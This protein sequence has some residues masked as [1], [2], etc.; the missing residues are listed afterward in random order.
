MIANVSPSASNYRRVEAYWNNI[1]LT[2][3]RR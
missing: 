3:I 1:F 2:L